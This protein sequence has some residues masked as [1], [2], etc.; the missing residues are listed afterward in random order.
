MK[1]LSRVLNII[2]RDLKAANV[3]LN[4]EDDGIKVKI[5][6]FGYALHTHSE[7]YFG[8]FGLGT[9]FALVSIFKYR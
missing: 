1:Y 4:K 6:D 2:H 8:Y 7:E 3:F 5:G 9:L